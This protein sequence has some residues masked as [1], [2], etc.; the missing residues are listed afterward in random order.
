MTEYSKEIVDCIVT[1]TQQLQKCNGD[2]ECIAQSGKDFRKN[3]DQV[4]PSSTK[5]EFDND[6][7]SYIFSTIFFLS[8]RLNKALIGLAETDKALDNWVSKERATLNKVDDREDRA[9]F[10]S[11]LDN[12]L[13][14]YF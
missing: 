11:D 6:K 5:L 10:E 9:K 14:E 8:N 2:P 13:S 4:F 3:M 12:I 1:W 7:I